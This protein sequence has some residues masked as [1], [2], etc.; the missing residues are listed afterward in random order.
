MV[1]FESWVPAGARAHIQ[2]TLE[3]DETGWPGINAYIN[4]YR[5][6]DRA[7]ENAVE[8]EREAACL[9][10]FARDVRMHDVY[11]NLQ[12]VLTDD[13]QYGYFLRAAWGANIDYDRY[14]NRVKEA[15]WLAPKIA[16]AALTLSKLLEQAGE[17]GGGM[18]PDEFYS[19]RYLLEN[20]DNH[21][22]HAH[23]LSIWRAVR[24]TITGPKSTRSEPVEQTKSAGGGFPRIQFRS[25]ELGEPVKIDPAEEQRNLIRYA[26]EKAPHLPAILRTVA[27]AATEWEPRERGAVGAA[28]SSRKQNQVAE[29]I[30]AFG[31]LLRDEYLFA[32][33]PPL[34][35]AMAGI[36]TVVLEVAADQDLTAD[37]VRLVLDRLADDSRM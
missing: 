22:L 34:F 18:V 35:A 6:D 16:E 33:G 11:A 28:I 32:F 37:A 26:W 20:T 1:R 8:L 3:G 21:E 36:A 29:Y 5:A 17:V 7:S 4:E 24:S 2:R 14:R 23:N 31:K 10:R 27:R 30:R 19:L 9:K 25:P 15:K 12:K 13:E